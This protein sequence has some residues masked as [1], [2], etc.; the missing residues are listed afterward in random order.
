M[1]LER[2]VIGVL[3][4]APRQA[5]SGNPI[6]LASSWI[7]FLHDRIV[8]T[9]P[10]ETGDFHAF[11]RSTRNVRNI[12][13]QD[14]FGRQPVPKHLVRYPSRIARPHLE[15]KGILSFLRYSH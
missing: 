2:L 8:E 13:I 14:G 6:I 11:D 1:L 3:A 12:D 4:A 5:C 15:A 9:T 10:T 7:D